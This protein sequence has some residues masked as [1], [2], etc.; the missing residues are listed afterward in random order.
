M[1]KK[2]KK[3]AQK[4]PEEEANEDVPE[5]KPQ[6]KQAKSSFDLK[7]VLSESFRGKLT[8]YISLNSEVLNLKGE[9]EGVDN[10]AEIDSRKAKMADRVEQASADIL[11]LE[12]GALEEWIGEQQV[13]VSEDMI[14]LDKVYSDNK[15]NLESTNSFK[16]SEVA[17]MIDPIQA[18]INEK[19]SAYD[20]Y[21]AL[22]RRS[23]DIYS[24]QWYL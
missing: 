8:Q 6:K 1:G 17:A 10:S 22:I 15:R 11:R 21:G 4:I 23:K 14:K 19:Q 3:A 12:L 20:S 24:W 16:P 5:E 9:A 2:A 18:R 13:Q 7:D